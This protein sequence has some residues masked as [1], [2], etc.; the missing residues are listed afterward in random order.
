VT[1]P[2]VNPF[3]P[4][5]R[6]TRPDL[7]SGR[8]VELDAGIKFLT[9]AAFGNVSHALI[10]GERGIGKSSLTSQIE[11]IAQGDVRF[12]TKFQSLLPENPFSFLVAEHIAQRG[13]GVAEITS[14]LLGAL[15]R[16]TSSRLPSIQWELA[17][18]FKIVK[19]KLNPN[20]PD[21]T[22]VTEFVDEIEKAWKAVAQSVDGILLV[23]DEIDRVAEER[24]VSTFLKIATEMLAARGLENVM[25]LLVGMIGVKEQLR[26]EH[27]SVPRVFETIPVRV[28]EDDESSEIIYNALSKTK[29]SITESAS[30]T[31]VGLAQGFPH[32]IQL[33]GSVA[34]DVDNDDVIDDDDLV[35]AI[36]IVVTEKLKEEFDAEYVA[37]GSGRNRDIIRAM[38]GYQSDNV[39]LAAICDALKVTQPQT[40]SS[41]NQLMTRNIIVRPD[42]GVYRFRDLLFGIYVGSLDIF[43]NKPIERRPRKR[44]AI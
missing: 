33:I 28:L 32:P 44:K 37:A 9:Q 30:D 18:D 31:I 23:I 29:T 6:L 25:L 14:G 13:E 3:T 15:H 10:T 35:E 8:T 20:K 38:A 5:K 42:R 2:K 22:L 4:G 34:F 24:G 40:S 7:F 17:I 41:I 43:G 11:G 16:V 36:R 26:S 27:P 1:I 12:A 39:P 21:R 19:G